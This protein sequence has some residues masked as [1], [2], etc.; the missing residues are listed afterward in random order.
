MNVALR[1]PVM[2]LEDFLAWEKRQDECWRSERWVRL[3]VTGD[4]VL[5]LPEIGVADAVGRRLC[6]PGAWHTNP[7]IRATPRR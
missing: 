5:T 3:T 2:S 4:D 1:H 7:L 6:G